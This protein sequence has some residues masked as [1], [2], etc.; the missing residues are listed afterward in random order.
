MK[1]FLKNISYLLL[2]CL[3][4]TS[5]DEV[6][7]SINIEPPKRKVIMEEFTGVRCTNCIDAHIKTEALLDQ[8][9][10][11]LIVISIHTGF[12]AGVLNE[13]TQD[14]K[15]PEGPELDAFLGPVSSFPSASIN[16]QLFS[17][18]D[19][20]ILGSSKWAGYIT[21]EL[22]KDSPVALTVATSYDQ[23]SRE[24]TVKPEITLFQDITDPVSIT[25]MITENNITDAQLSDN[26][27]IPD[28]T[29]KHVLR[30]VLT[31]VEGNP[32]T[33][34][35]VANS[36]LQE[37]YSITLPA[38]WAAENVSAVVSVHFP[39]PTYSVL[40]AEEVHIIE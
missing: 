8:H 39:S 3:F 29:H 10:D 26:G 5:C 32:L 25:V 36:P 38:D 6:G 37:Q 13:S 18:E 19:G 30:D 9:G 16:R 15:I 7:P 35:L 31:N 40:Q 17:G 21:T 24:L 12:F 34:T 14:F 20:L 33:G 2:A 27:T 4:I 28:Y 23:S 1:F 22:A 11:N